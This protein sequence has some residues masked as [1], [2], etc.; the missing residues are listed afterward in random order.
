[1]TITKMLET[2]GTVRQI[3]VGPDGATAYS[4]NES[5]WVDIIPR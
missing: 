5:G 3:V 1:M 2:N 4:A